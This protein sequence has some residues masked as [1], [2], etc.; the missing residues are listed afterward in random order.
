MIKSCKEGNL[1]AVQEL[2]QRQIPFNVPDAAGNSAFHYAAL[3]GHTAVMEFLLDCG[4]DIEAPAAMARRPLHLAALNGQTQTVSALIKR[5]ADLSSR[6]EGGFTALHHACREGHVLAAHFLVSRGAIV[7]ALD[8]ERHTPLHWS[9]Y[10]GML[11]FRRHSLLVLL[12]YSLLCLCTGHEGCMLYLL[13]RGADFTRPDEI[14][15]T[16]LHWACAKGHVRIR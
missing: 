1:P 5:G 10:F 6:D 3:N 2:V 8:N 11:F 7:D 9:A 15:C 13:R 14:G 16:P 4:A 12:K